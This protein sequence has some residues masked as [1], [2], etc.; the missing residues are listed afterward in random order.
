MK[1]GLALCIAVAAG[2]DASAAHAQADLFSPSTISGVVDARVVAADGEASWIDGG[3]GK[4]RFGDEAGVRLAEAA[5]AWN[6]RF[7]DSLSAVVTA[8][9][10][11]G[12]DPHID[13][14]EAYIAWRGDPGPV[15]FSARAGLYWPTLSLE[16]D[17]LL[18]TVPDTLTPSAINS[19]IG[20]EVK[21]VGAE[22]TAR[23]DLFGQSLSGTVGVFGYGD[24]AGT[25]LS[26]RGWAL[27]DLKNTAIGVMPLPPLSPYM[28]ARQAPFTTSLLELDHRAGVYGRVEW[29][30]SPNLTLDLFGYDNR[31]DR[32]SN[33]DDNEWAWDTRFAAVGLSWRV[34]G[35]TTLRAQALDGVTLM[36]FRSSALNQIWVDVGFTSAY[37]SATREMGPGA[38]TGRLDA[39]AT[40]DHTLTVLD[41]NDED[42]WAATV[43]WR[44]DLTPRASL[45]FE[46]VRVESDRPS[47]ALAELEP[48]Q[49]QMQA[50]TALRYA[51]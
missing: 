25:L 10:Q 26:F 38:L 44:W 40:D 46:A 43:A 47:R 24:T 41:N 2:L 16:H 22:V 4:L 8:E 33:N 39:F 30:P 18:W 31:G 5:V 35:R 42:G 3:F 45:V 1:R 19:W 17:G 32:T 36:G 48:R 12:A 50:Q 14:S 27:H 11:D 51:F 34:D 49:V 15:R 7:T 20:E 9:F 37:V 29:A 13:I 28:A 6:P 21:V 23:G